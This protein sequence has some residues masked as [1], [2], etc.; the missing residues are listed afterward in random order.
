[1]RKKLLIIKSNDLESFCEA[2]NLLQ[3]ADFNE[4]NFKTIYKNR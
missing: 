1:M 3:K 4:K 2:I